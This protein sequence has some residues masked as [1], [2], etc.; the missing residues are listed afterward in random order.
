MRAPFAGSDVATRLALDA[1]RVRRQATVLSAVGA[2]SVA[3]GV[4]QGLRHH[5][6][7]AYGFTGAGASLV[8]LSV[9]LHFSADAALSRAVWEFNRQF[10]R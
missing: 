6:S 5:R 8:L 2:L 4:V 7:A 10:T 3:A 1:T 9:P